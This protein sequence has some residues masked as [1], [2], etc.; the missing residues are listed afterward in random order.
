MNKPEIHYSFPTDWGR[1]GFNK[2]HTAADI[3]DWRVIKVQRFG[4]V[5]WKFEDVASKQFY[6]PTLL[7]NGIII[8]NGYRSRAPFHNSYPSMDEM[9]SVAVLDYEGSMPLTLTR[10]KLDGDSELPFEKELFQSLIL[11]MLA[12]LIMRKPNSA[13]LVS[14]TTYFNHPILRANRIVDE[15]GKRVL[16][17]EESLILSKAG[18]CLPYTRNIKKL[19]TN[20]IVQIWTKTSQ[21]LSCTIWSYLEYAILCNHP[22]SHS[23]QLVKNTLYESSFIHDFRIDSKRIYLPKQLGV[24][25]LNGG[26][27]MRKDIWS[28]LKME[29]ELGN[30]VSIIMNNPPSAT[31]DDSFFESENGLKVDALIEIYISPKKFRK[32][33]NHDKEKIEELNKYVEEVLDK[34]FADEVFIPYDLKER[35]KKYPQAFKYLSEYM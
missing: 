27:E 25:L 1:A 7:C 15:D 8:P 5:L 14:D 11:D 24:A 10:D 23:N 13:K 35:R 6:D 17:G 30:M 32:F 4:K 31:I 26:I 20:K 28:R 9:P 2:Y 21:K 12:K 19:K 16:V 22:I 3:N 34:C 18:Y 29:K 33:N